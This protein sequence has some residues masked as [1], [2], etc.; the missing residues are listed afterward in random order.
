VQVEPRLAGG[1]TLDHPPPLPE[2]KQ[3]LAKSFLKGL[4]KKGKEP[5][6]EVIS[7]A[8]AGFA[9]IA[10]GATIAFGAGFAAIPAG[11]Q[12]HPA[13]NPLPCKRCKGNGFFQSSSNN[14]NFF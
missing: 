1:S 11:R 6:L 10:L 14:F 8:L 7:A 5:H 2:R 3:F 12:P 9:T 4:K 13:L